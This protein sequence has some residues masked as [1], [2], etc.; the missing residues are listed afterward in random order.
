MFYSKSNLKH[1]NGCVKDRD[2][3]FRFRFYLNYIVSFATVHRNC[4][5]CFFTDLCRQVGSQN[6]SLTGN[7]DSAPPVPTL[8]MPCVTVFWYFLDRFFDVKTGRKKP[9]SFELGAFF[10][11]LYSLNIFK[12]LA[13]LSTRM[14]KTL[15]MYT[16]F[17]HSS[18]KKKIL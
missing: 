2:R 6:I 15:S 4:Q 5:N 17:S 3:I 9:P 7:E 1:V 18:I 8:S 11:S 10:N 12:I 13:L 16:I 14:W